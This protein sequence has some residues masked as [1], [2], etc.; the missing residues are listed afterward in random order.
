MEHHVSP[1]TELVHRLGVHAPDHLVMA[2]LSALVLTGLALLGTRRLSVESPGGLQQVLEVAVGGF[3]DF[4]DSIIPHGARKHVPVMFAFAAFILISNLFGLVPTLSPPTQNYGV[5]LALALMSFVYY[6]AISLKENGILGH[7][8]HLCGPV[9]FIAPLFFVIELVSHSARILSLSLRL[10][11]NISGEHMASSIFYT[12]F[13]GFF[14]PLPMMALGLLGACLQT[15][16]FVL[17]SMV[18]IALMQEH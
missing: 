11:G 13:G 2:T 5:T 9:A 10:M 8:K 4:I 16:I 1:W 7:L 12:F 17:L 15:F 18:Y 6:N 3:A 14:V